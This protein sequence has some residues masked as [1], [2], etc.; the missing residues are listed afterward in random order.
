MREEEGD[1]SSNKNWSPPLHP[2]V[3]SPG[4]LPTCEG[5]RRS[6]PLR[7]RERE[8]CVPCRPW[9]V[10]SV[11]TVQQ[12]S[13]LRTGQAAAQP[14]VSQR[15]DNQ[16]G[17]GLLTQL[18]ISTT[19]P[20]LWSVSVSMRQLY[21]SILTV[22]SASLI[23]GGGESINFCLVFI[24]NYQEL[25]SLKLPISASPLVTIHQFSTE[26]SIPPVRAAG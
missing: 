21:I 1:L 19:Y 8:R 3:S 24:I 22:F 2:S 15:D 13:G 4:W 26:I 11:L 9:L 17:R 10:L 7:E 18:Q 6:L 14:P 25:I 12:V 16:A 23:D 5:L 20:H